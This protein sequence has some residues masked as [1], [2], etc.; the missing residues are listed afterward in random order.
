MSS[1]PRQRRQEAS[2]NAYQIFSDIAL[3]MLGTFIFLLVV[4]LITSRMSE[5]NELPK[6][7]KELAA[8]Q[9]ALNVAE[10]DK[11]RIKKDFEKILVTDPEG[12]VDIILE[13]ANIGRKDFDLFV[14]GL[15]DIPGKDI[16]LVVDATGSMHG[17][18]SFLVPI[19][20]LIVTR[21]DKQLSAI[22]W[23]SD[24]TA[25]TYTGTMGDMFDGL[26]SGAPFSGNTENIGLALRTAANG[27]VALPGAYMLIGD[28]P[29][30]DTIHYN[31]IPRPVFTLPFGRS[32]PYTE[33][34]YLSLAEKTGGKMLRLD[35]K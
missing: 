21:A 5:Q 22:T 20:R 12:E 35:F 29:S 3:M 32:D 8:L 13:S 19:L 25:K 2:S 16:H 4:V 30:D 31:E 14:Q 33:R 17:V 15:K 18:S 1:N 26:M 6:L 28:E 7:K 11:K 10:T 34:E 23:F 9:K 24:R 27:G